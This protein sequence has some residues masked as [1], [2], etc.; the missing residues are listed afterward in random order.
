MV[1]SD[2]TLFCR[3]QNE[4]EET[5]SKWNMLIDHVFCLG[6][7]LF[8][9]CYANVVLYCDKTASVHS[10]C[11]GG[12]GGT[13]YV[14]GVILLFEIYFACVNF[15]RNGMVLLMFGFFCRSSHP[16]EISR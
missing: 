10:S 12:R 14:S 6:H 13:G 7:N 2:G 9:L 11:R 15:C 8:W 1:S 3:L 5:S 16:I 4:D